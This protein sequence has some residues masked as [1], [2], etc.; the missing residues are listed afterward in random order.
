MSGAAMGQTGELDQSAPH[1]LSSPNWATFNI[2]SSRWVWQQQIRPGVSGIL[3]GIVITVGQGPAGSRFTVRVRDGAFPSNNPALFEAE[4]TRTTADYED[5]FIDMTAAN[6]PLAAGSPFVFEAIGRNEQV[7]L[8]G[9]HV[10]PE[11]GAPLYPEPL[12]TN[13]NPEP[14]GWRFGFDTYVLTG[15]CDADFNGDNQVDFFD[16]LDFAGAFDAEDPSADFNG[17]NQVDFF[18]YLDFVAS[19]DN[20][21]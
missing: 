19:F 7:F 21:Q 12:G 9:S 17:D 13:G 14:P 15:G 18:D 10:R 5:I 8:V 1:T 16:Y 3:E 6:I 20:C 4:I 11:D 2:G